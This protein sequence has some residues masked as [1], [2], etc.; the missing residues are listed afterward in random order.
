[1]IKEISVKLNLTNK[2]GNIVGAVGDVTLE[3][4]QEGSVKMSGYR[5][6]VPDGKPPWVSAPARHG[7][8]TW[9]DVVTLRGPIKRSVDTAVLQEY[10]Q[11]KKS[12]GKQ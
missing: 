1:M 3:F 2:P 5:V 6:M 10:E 8:T 12:L 9:F 7:K 4:G 11:M